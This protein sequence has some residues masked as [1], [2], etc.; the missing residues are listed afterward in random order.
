MKPGS[1]CTGVQDFRSAGVELV[2]DGG[3]RASVKSQV[4]MSV[5]NP[6]DPPGNRRAETRDRRAETGERRVFH[7]T[8]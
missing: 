7:R 2:D 3:D 8:G 4:Q 1:R 5:V 6:H